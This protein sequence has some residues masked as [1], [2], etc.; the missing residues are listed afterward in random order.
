MSK[1]IFFKSK[2]NRKINDR[3]IVE[4]VIDI[5]KKDDLRYRDIWNMIKYNLKLFGI[6]LDFLIM[7]FYVKIRKE[8]NSIEKLVVGLRKLFLYISSVF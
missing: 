7:I 6:F 3:N 2:W 5:S 4:E 1:V 8:Y